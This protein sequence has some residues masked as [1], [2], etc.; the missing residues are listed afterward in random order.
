LMMTMMSILSALLDTCKP[1]VLT[2]LLLWLV[3]RLWHNISL[4]Q[5]SLLQCS[6]PPGSMGLPFFG[7]T[8]SFLAKGS[9]YYE[10]KFKIYGRL[11]M[12]HLLGAPTIRVRGSDHLHKILHGEDDI[13][14]FEYPKAI[15]GIL[16]KNTLVQARGQHHVILRKRVATAF[17]HSALEGYLPLITEPIK[18]A[19]EHWCN[20]P[21][22]ITYRS[23]QELV[24]KLNGSIL[25]GFHYSDTDVAEI[26]EL[27]F[28]IDNG[29]LALPIDLPNTAYRKAMQA[30]KKLREKI[31]D[32]IRMKENLSTQEDDQD[33]LRVLMDADLSHFGSKGESHE[34]VSDNAFD[35]LILGFGTLSSACTSAVLQLAR[36]P[37]VV[38]KIKEE[39]EAARIL[40]PHVPIIH[41]SLTDCKYVNNVVK[42]IL[43][44]NPPVPSSFRKV[45]KT[46][47]L[48]GLQIPKGWTVLYSIRDTL[49][50]SEHYKN[51]DIFDPDRYSPERREDKK[52]GR[53]NYPVFGGGQRACPGKFLA[54]MI[55]KVLIIELVRSTKFELL[56][57][58]KV[59]MRSI[60]VPH[61]VDGLPVKFTSTRDLVI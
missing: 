55:L 33:V 10:D 3:T 21:R 41:K 7:E 49:K 36:H 30:G 24:C 28:Q 26:T 38:E 4:H 6:L 39:L 35:L 56:E 16:G 61:P 25:C 48:D 42:E 9:Q 17:T 32:R 44:N 12:T 14:S 22:T 2:S 51:K 59:K 58:E 54:T 43:R 23:M 37:H 60:P 13:V 11:F 31:A 29:I 15:T 34:I 5:G 53:Y 18:D 50:F 27:L 52:G 57:P 47:I 46:F 1:L 40:D 20:Q 8:L 45:V 19:I